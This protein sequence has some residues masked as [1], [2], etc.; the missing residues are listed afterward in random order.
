MPLIY[1]EEEKDFPRLQEE[2][3]R[4]LEDYTIFPWKAVQPA[5]SGELLVP[6]PDAFA[7]STA[8]F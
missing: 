6:S 5:A 7:N 1:G 4:V 2:L 3:I 8:L